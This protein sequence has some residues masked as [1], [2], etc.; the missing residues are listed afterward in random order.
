MGFLPL[1]SFFKNHRFLGLALAPI[2]GC[3][4][5]TFAIFS[6]SS[7]TEPTVSAVPVESP[8]PKILPP[9]PKNPSSERAEQMLSQ[10]PDSMKT[11]DSEIELPDLGEGDLSQDPAQSQME[12]RHK[13]IRAQGTDQE[14]LQS[15]GALEDPHGK[16]F[17]EWDQKFNLEPE[18]KKG[19]APSLVIGTQKARELFKDSKW[20]ESLVVVNSL[21]KHYPNLPQ[22]LLMKGTL[23]Q[24]MG[25]LDL[26][27]GAFKK[28]YKF[29]PSV[30]LKVQIQ[31]LESLLAQREQLRSPAK[32]Q[33]VPLGAQEIK[34]IPAAKTPGAK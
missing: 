21:L 26:A 28:A 19:S 33:V 4:F 32:G 30:K 9:A 7:R 20:E 6:C 5:L 29:E 12:K 14:L 15:T 13:E 17:G 22:L 11:S 34:S 31:Y 2:S 24:K 27:L 25:Y 1:A 16:N 8:K 18:E 3:G 10:I 23:H